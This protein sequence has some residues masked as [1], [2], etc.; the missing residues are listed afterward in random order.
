M[1]LRFLRRI[2]AASCCSLV[3][4]AQPSFA[5]CENP[6]GVDELIDALEGGF[7]AIDPDDPATFTPIW[8]AAA[9]GEDTRGYVDSERF[10][11]TSTQCESD[12]FVIYARFGGSTAAADLIQSVVDFRNAF[13]IS[14]TLDGQ[15]V[16]LV[17]F[18]PYIGREPIA[19]ET[20]RGIYKVGAIFE[21][22]DLDPG[23]Y[24][25]VMLL[26]SPLFGNIPFAFNFNLLEVAPETVLTNLADT[27]AELNVKSGIT[28]ALDSKLQ[29]AL[30]ALAE[31]SSGDIPSASGKLG[32]FINSVE[33][34]RGKAISDEDADAL[35]TAAEAALALLNSP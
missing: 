21:P 6:I 19:P 1:T 12:H 17:D 33:A 32:A 27:V 10:D 23:S 7:A 14:L 16:G 24:S 34:Q 26:A 5:I 2:L 35:I 28:S 20:T 25:G 30:D 22:G 3:F 15:P 4:F 9:L 11:V 18:A 13:D 31:A 8:R 29:N